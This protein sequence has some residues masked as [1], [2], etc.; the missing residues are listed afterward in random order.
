MTIYYYRGVFMCENK[1]ENLDI[2]I[3]KA[4]TGHEI[5]KVQGYY[6]HSK[7]DP[8]Q[9]AEKIVK[10][11][12]KLNHLHILFGNGHGYISDALSEKISDKEFLIVIEPSSEIAELGIKLAK[13]KIKNKR[14]IYCVGMNI[15]KFI[16]IYTPIA[17]QFG[18]RVNIILSP[19]YDKIFKDYYKDILKKIIEITNKYA[20]NI[21][22]IQMFSQE[23]QKNFTYNLY[24]A[25]N[26]CT[27][28][29]LQ[30]KYNCPVVIASGGPSL[31][32]QL[33]LLKSIRENIL[34]I[35]SGSTINTLIKNN[36]T[37]DYVVTID[38]NYRNY[39]HFENLDLKN[40]DIIYSL[41]N[42]ERIL[43]KFNRPS[44]SFVSDTTKN[45]QK[46]AERILDKKITLLDAGASVANFAL[47]VAQRIS[48]GPIT[49]IG[50]DLAYTNNQSHAE[51]NI[52]KREIDPNK[53]KDNEMF[54][55]EGYLNDEVLTDYAF[56]V[57][58]EVFEKLIKKF[59]DSE[60]IFNSTEGG[61]KLKGF[62]QLS[63]S[64]FIDKYV[65]KNKKVTKVNLSEF[66][67]RTLSE[68]K[69][70]LVRINNEIFD[71]I[72]II[73]LTQEAQR[74]LKNNSS[75]V[76]FDSSVLKD[77]EKIDKKLKKIFSKGLMSL[78][79]QPIVIDTFNNYLPRENETE[80]EVYKRTYAHS[81]DLYSRLEIAAKESKVYLE[82]LKEKIEAKIK[83]I[84][85]DEVSK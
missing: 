50:Q 19:N 3:E 9:E 6:L 15:E 31:T 67:V 58:K 27:V 43:Q 76:Q 13:E 47:C 2:Q 22:T 53:I 83:I 30:N 55:V 69:S 80:I 21:N 23:W 54:Y 70:F 32:K 66:P 26:D 52:F 73:R 28:D 42:N 17:H 57:M 16:E 38:G 77:L 75:N 78:I 10:A 51:Y 11:N 5:L 49:L 40:T 25:F 12:Y 39:Q 61:V 18:K 63:F 72:K 1:I 71:H 79:V 41:S 37:P 62:Q 36:I 8:I 20:V 68:W 48:S 14:L 44:I 65:D 29:D 24:Y 64:E 7:Y 60:R 84:S 46:Y 35:A 74:K 56:L 85:K 82:S 45:I 33:E 59:P 81:N 34:L 4:K